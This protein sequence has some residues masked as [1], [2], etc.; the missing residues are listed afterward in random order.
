MMIYYV[1][2]TIT[3][4]ALTIQLIVSLIN[5]NQYPD[6]AGLAAGWRCIIS[7]SVP[8]SHSRI[9]EGTQITPVSHEEIAKEVHR[10]TRIQYNRTE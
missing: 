6:N 3:Q 8:G 2:Y 4:A 9:S 7:A 1:I 5:C 10:K